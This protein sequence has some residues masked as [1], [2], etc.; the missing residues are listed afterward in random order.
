MKKQR[1]GLLARCGWARS[2]KWTN[3]LALVTL[4]VG[5]FSASARA[6]TFD[7][8]VTN[9]CALI[10]TCVGAPAASGGSTTAFS[11][12]S[13][14][15]PERKFEKLMGPW[16]LYIAGDYEYFHKQ[17]TTFEPGYTNNIWRAAVGADYALSNALLVGGALR[18][19]RDNGDFRGGGKFNT[20]SYGFLVHSNYV[21][22]PKFFLDANA[23]YLRKNYSIDRVA[24]LL[25]AG[26]PTPQ[27]TAKGDPDGNELTAGV[28][29]GY[30]FSLQNI[31]F[32]PRLGM[33]YKYTSIGRYRERGTT[34]QELVYNSQN[35]HSLTSALGVQA[36]MALS[37]G[38]GVFIPQL[39]A[40]YAH[41]FLDNQRHIGF[42]LANDPAA[43]HFRFENDRPDRNYFNL[44]GGVVLQL[45]RGIAP[46]INYRALVG[47]RDQSSHRVT[48]GVRLEF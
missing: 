48:A 1:K 20:D 26:I 30:D 18:Y 14:P 37:T 42:R 29:G 4:I 16:N 6:Q 31:T 21:P 33:A 27:G 39:T 23:G 15:A 9:A 36:S 5:G 7:Q 17:I 41:E 47:Y 28:N 34:Q 19:A 13:S 24:S 44:G 22:A 46:F 35:E 38:F 3:A 40:E 11:N 8:A 12:G 45:A 2:I 10:G 25:I 43:T 32:G